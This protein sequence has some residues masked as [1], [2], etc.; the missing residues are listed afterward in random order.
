MLLT[1]AELLRKLDSREGDIYRV[2]VGAMSTD[3]RIALRRDDGLSAVQ[4]EGLR[5]K[6]DRLDAV[7]RSGPRWCSSICRGE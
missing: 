6:L 4:L 7:C 5:V 1:R 2:K 3:P